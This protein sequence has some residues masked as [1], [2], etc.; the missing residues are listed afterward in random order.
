[1]GPARLGDSWR[2]RA[3]LDAD[4]WGDLADL[5]WIDPRI[6]AGRFRGGA[7]VEVPG[8]VEVDFERFEVELEASN[9]L[10]DGW[11]RF[12]QPMSLRSMEVT[13]SPLAVSRL[14]PWFRTDFPLDGWLSGQATFSGSLADLVATGRL[15]LIP[16]GFGGAATTAD[17]NG[18]IHL[19]ENPGATGFEVRLDTLNY[20]VL[21]SLW[22]NAPV[23]GTGTGLL[24]LDG[25]ADGG[26]AIVAD[27]THEADLASTS[28]AVLEG[29]IRRLDDGEWLMD[30]GGDLAPL[31]IGAF[32]RL[33]PGLGLRGSLAGPV[34]VQ[35]R[36][37]DLRVT[38][39][40]V[41][42]GGGVV[43]NAA[44]DLRAPGSWYRL[45]AEADGLPL[46]RLTTGLPERSSWTGRLELEGSGLALDSMEASATLVAN[47]SRI[48]PVRVDAVAASFRVLGGVLVTDTLEAS[49]GGVDVTGRG[50]FG[51]AEGTW[52]SSRLSFDAE[53]LVGL[54]PLVMLVVTLDPSTSYVPELAIKVMNIDRISSSVRLSRVASSA[55]KGLASF[56][57]TSISL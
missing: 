45:D 26:V 15:T 10:A 13:V 24:E 40:L 1:M 50:R 41:T 23:A 8:T 6:P 11:V 38:A 18:T 17:F 20:T 30:V 2:I 46:S 39:D 4:G 27:F 12:D 52:G 19:G 33:A 25:R 44:L 9:I 53:T 16:T 42:E 54:R 21:E 48:G 5:A 43:L 49:V 55:I 3:S 29:R 31:S 37:D 36:L 34:R 57:C 51:L 32:A 47:D 14:A 35:G 28:R 7:T 22:P 56:P